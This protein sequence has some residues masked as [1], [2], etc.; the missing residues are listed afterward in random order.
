MH[1]CTYLYI[2]VHA[3]LKSYRKRQPV[4]MLLPIVKFKT[5]CITIQKDKFADQ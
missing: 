1:F 4:N 2:F 5:F 3:R